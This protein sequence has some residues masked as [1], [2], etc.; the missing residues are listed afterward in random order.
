MLIL[1]GSFKGVMADGH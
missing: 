1:I